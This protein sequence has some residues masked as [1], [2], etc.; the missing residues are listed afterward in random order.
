MRKLWWSLALALVP[1]VA[2]AAQ[3]LYMVLPDGEKFAC[4]QGRKNKRGEL[5]FR[6][7]IPCEPEATPTPHRTAAIPRPTATPR[8]YDPCPGGCMIWD[9]VSDLYRCGKG[10]ECR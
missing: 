3:P 9:P 8:P 5:V 7:K 10:A 1:T 2:L 4:G 6:V